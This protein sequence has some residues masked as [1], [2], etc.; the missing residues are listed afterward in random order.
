VDAA[1]VRLQL[2]CDLDRVGFPEL[3]QQRMCSHQG[4]TLICMCNRG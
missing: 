1:T 2:V 3:M 4:V